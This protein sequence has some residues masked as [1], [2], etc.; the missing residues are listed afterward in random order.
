MRQE[1]RAIQLP[2]LR[3]KYFK[4]PVQP[5]TEPVVH[6]PHKGAK[7]KGRLGVRT[8]SSQN[9]QRRKGKITCPRCALIARHASRHFRSSSDFWLPPSLRL[10]QPHTRLSA[11]NTVRVRAASRIGPCFVAFFFGAEVVYHL[12]PDTTV[13]QRAGRRLNT[14]QDSAGIA[15][16]HTE[17]L[18]HVAS[19]TSSS[20][21]LHARVL[22]CR[23]L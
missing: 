3:P 7:Q 8:S 4:D 14:Q 1:E 5:W 18:E 23:Q 11:C 12:L 6:P 17:M 21:A 15:G 16:S 2:A 22:A 13:V 19:D 10:I 20:T 9:P